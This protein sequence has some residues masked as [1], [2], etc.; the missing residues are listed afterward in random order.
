MTVKAAPGDDPNCVR[1]AMTVQAPVAIAWRVFTGGIG[2]W[3][4]LGTHKIGKAP[5][6]DAVIEPHVGGRWYERGD[7]GSTCDW[8][9]VLV[10]EPPARLVLSW[11]VSANWQHDSSLNTEVEVRFTPEGANATRLELEHRLLD[12]Y[13]TRR[14]EMRGIFESDGGWT[15]LLQSFAALAAKEKVR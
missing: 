1:K 6:V 8:G 15:M 4:P 2:R 13:G 11:Q 9:R 7:D 12:G 5:A 10:W 3:W 14:D